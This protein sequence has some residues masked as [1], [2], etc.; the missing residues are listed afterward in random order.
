MGNVIMCG[1]FTLRCPSKLL[2]D[3]FGLSHEPSLEA[4]YN[5]A[6]TQP[7]AVI[8]VLRTH[9]ATKERELVPMRWG[10][11]PAWADDPSI[12]NRMINA[13]AESVSSKPAF[14]GAFKYRRCLV[15]ADGF[16]EWKKEGKRKQ[17]VYIRRKDEQPFAFAGLWE[18]W[19]REGEVIESC[20]IITTE[21]NELVSEFHDRMPVILDPA[22]YD[23]WL[24]PEVQDPEVLEPLLRPYPSGE[25]EVYLVSRLVNDPRH[26]DP[27]CVE[28]ESL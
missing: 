4:R 20:T 21:A 23:V 14:R 11:I 27:K 1:R 25:M 13:R 22:D 28:P 12:G 19:E 24:D 15:P 8:R 2:A 7:V 26:E 5:V 17:P 16:Y 9:P 3:A 6:P 18:E 10:L